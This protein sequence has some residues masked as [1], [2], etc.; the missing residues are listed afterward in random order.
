MIRPGIDD[1][2]RGF[3]PDGVKFEDPTIICI[4][5]FRRYKGL[6]YAV[7][8]MKFVLEKVPR[9]KLVIVGNGDPTELRDEVSRT[10]YSRS[11]TVLERKPNTWDPEAPGVDPEE[12]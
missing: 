11:I 12:G 5:R 10:D 8:S 9:A 6:T 1:S 3:E 7:R 4:S 2:F